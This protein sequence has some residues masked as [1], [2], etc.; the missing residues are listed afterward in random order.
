MKKGTGDEAGG[1]EDFGVER[2]EEFRSFG[3]TIAA[4][5]VSSEW[6]SYGQAPA[7]SVGMT[8][9][10]RADASLL[11]RAVEGVPKIETGN[12]RTGR[13]GSRRSIARAHPLQTARIVELKFICRWLDGK[14]VRPRN[15]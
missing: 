13:K 2:M 14:T 4:I 1:K 6:L 7:T 9:N 12:P 3:R 10:A 11:R 8:E 15:G 5:H